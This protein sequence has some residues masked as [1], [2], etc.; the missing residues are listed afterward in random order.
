[1]AEAWFAAYKN[2]L[3][4]RGVWPTIAKLRTA[5]FDYIETPHQP[6]CQ[7]ATL[8]TRCGKAMAES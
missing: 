7:A 6:I 3:V 1:V 5:T 2:E 4:Y 8:E